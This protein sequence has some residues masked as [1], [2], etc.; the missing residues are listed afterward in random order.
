MR[1]LV[2]SEICDTISGISYILNEY[3]NT[4]KK[5]MNVIDKHTP[6]NVHILVA[7]DEKTIRDIIQEALSNEGYV[8]SSVED[9]EKALK[10]LAEH[11]ADVV[12]TDI[13]MPNLDG[14]ELTRIVK[15]KYD[16]D[17][18]IITGFVKDYSYEDIIE[19]G[20]SDFIQ[21]PVSM[22]ELIIRVK[23][24][25][26]E[27]ALLAERIRTEKALRESEKRYQ[28]LS[29][30]DGLMKLYNVRHFYNQLKLEIE[31]TNR[32]HH[33]LTLLILDIDDFKQ[34]NDNFGHLEGNKVLIRLS[35]FIRESVR[36]TD[37]AYRYGGEEF[38]IILPETKGEKGLVVAERI[39][40]C[41]KNEGFSPIPGNKIH[42][43]VSTGIAQFI[44]NEPLEDFIRR[45][46]KSMY[47]AKKQGKDR[48][49]LADSHS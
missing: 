14:L 33:P 22:N 6:G 2:D 40:T 23:R 28:E 11:N 38:A 10:F 4:G 36:H 47:K 30:T 13:M 3:V 49:I 24:V 15:E 27:K 43:S 42:I 1:Y 44:L 37:S 29:I 41:L 9:G 21:K 5:K 25:L 32:Y 31:R 18:I 8:C 17:V 26:R 39:R 46:D 34:Y 48:I 16:S 35:E 20:A 19:I 7:E 12:I 45:A